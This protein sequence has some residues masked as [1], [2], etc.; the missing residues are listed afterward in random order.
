MRHMPVSNNFV[1]DNDNEASGCSGKKHGWARRNL[2]FPKNKF[3]FVRNCSSF[4]QL[5]VP[6][7]IG[8]QGIR[9]DTPKQM[10]QANKTTPVQCKYMLDARGTFV[11][12][13]EMM[14]PEVH[15]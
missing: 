5:K 10:H 11:L 8:N 7:Q 15:D 1:Q 3:T 9:K 14:Q 12:S 13:R 6:C 4:L 2:S